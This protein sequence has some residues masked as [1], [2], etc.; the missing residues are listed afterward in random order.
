MRHHP[1]H[2]L[3]DGVMPPRTEN[4]Q[5]K[6]PLQS[7]ARRVL[8]PQRRTL[9]TTP[10]FTTIATRVDAIATGRRCDRTQTTRNIT[11]IFPPRTRP[12]SSFASTRVIR[13][14]PDPQ[15]ARARMDGCRHVRHQPPLATTTTTTHVPQFAKVHHRIAP[16]G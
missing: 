16:R 9:S 3:R 15:V 7:I 8:K 10:F 11:R 12:T 1:N 13:T 5:K 14:H 2:A 6:Q 4:R